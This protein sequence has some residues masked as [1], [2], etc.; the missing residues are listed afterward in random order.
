M[1]DDWF[2][3]LMDAFVEVLEE[4]Q[5]M[6]TLLG[7]IGGD[8]SGCSPLDTSIGGVALTRHRPHGHLRIRQPCRPA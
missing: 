1:R 6:L 7:E 2:D 8:V 5:A 4:H 3:Q